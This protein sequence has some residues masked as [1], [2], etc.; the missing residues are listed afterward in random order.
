MKLN[1]IGIIGG[2]ILI[3]SP[4]LAWISISAY[5]FTFSF[6]LLDMVSLGAAAA[7]DYILILIVLILLIVGGI[8]SFLKGLIGGI[9]GLV[10][11]IIYTALALTGGVP[12]SYFGIGYYL[13]WI[14][15]IISIASIIYKPRA[16]P[17]P[18]AVPPPPPPP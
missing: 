16:A 12:I 14:G 11:V 8:V 15:A 13:G 18:T 2:I 7:L 1:P 9:I 5:G 3:I 6:S 10:G 17:P 4:F